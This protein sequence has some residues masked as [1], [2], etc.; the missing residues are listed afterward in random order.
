MNI[1]FKY[2]RGFYLITTIVALTLGIGLLNEHLHA[3][4]ALIPSISATAFVSVV[5]FLYDRVLWRIFPQLL[6][7]KDISGRYTGDLFSDFKRTKKPIQIVFEITQTAS[8]VHVR[9][10]TRDSTGRT[11]W[12]ESLN[13]TIEARADGSMRL[14]FAYR[15]EGEATQAEMTEHIGFCCPP[16]VRVVVASHEPR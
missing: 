7:V 16:C 11:T 5:L 10:F 13:E 8:C 2:Y 14:S 15:N 9:Q 12:S 4:S 6:Q 1:S 3:A